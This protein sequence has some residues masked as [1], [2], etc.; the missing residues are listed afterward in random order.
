MR[1]FDFIDEG[2]FASTIDAENKN[3]TM[4]RVAHFVYVAC[5]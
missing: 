1:V 2:C 3:A 5:C 4:Q